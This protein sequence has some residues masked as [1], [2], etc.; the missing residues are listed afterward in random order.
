MNNKATLTLVELAVMVLVLALCGAL[1]LS[2]FAWADT[3]ARED[4]VRQE[5]LL[6]L[7]NAGEALKHTGGDVQKAAELYGAWEDGWKVSGFEMIAEKL[8][9]DL[10]LLG[11]ARLEIW[12]DGKSLGTLTVCWQEVS[13]G[14]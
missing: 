11:S 3:K 13:Y 6:V 2:A 4:A 10:A 12:Q 8:P 5:A 7:Q 9:T 1:C 14:E